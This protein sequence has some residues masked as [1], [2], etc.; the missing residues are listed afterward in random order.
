MST[1]RKTLV[2]KFQR[3]PSNTSLQTFLVVL[4]QLDHIWPDL[5]VKLD[6]LYKEL[7]AEND[8]VKRLYHLMGY[9]EGY[10]SGKEVG[11]Q[12]VLNHVQS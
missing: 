12:Q 7:L 9:I 1:D 6:E 8:Q 10:K 3:L 11:V 4:S 5:E 2:A